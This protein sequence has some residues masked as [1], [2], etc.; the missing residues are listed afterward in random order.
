M[1]DILRKGSKWLSN[2]MQSCTSTDIVYIRNG[3]SKTIPAIFGQTKYERSD[4]YGMKTG[5]FLSDFLIRLKDL[6]VY[7]EQ[8]DRIIADGRE[9]EVLELGQEG[10][11]RWSDPYG[12]RM[13]VHTKLIGEMS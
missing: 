4:D 1:N 9:Y 7:P 8:G 10:C 3:E 11:W 6:E 2:K 13:R 5:S 12:I